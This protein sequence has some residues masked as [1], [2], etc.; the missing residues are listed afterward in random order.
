MLIVLNGYPGVGKLTIGQIVAERLSG[1]LLDNHTVYNPA[2]ALTAFKSPAF[3]AA[4]R[5]MQALTD[6]LIDRLDADTPLVL[7]ETLAGSGPWG[8]ECWSRIEKLGQIRGPFYV[9]HLLCDLEENMRRIE[10]PGRASKRKPRDAEMALRNHKDGYRLYGDD[11]KNLL[12]LDV[13]DLSPDRAAMEVCDWI[14]LQ[15]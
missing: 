7:T 8:D 9:V 15:S 2:F 12:R 4:A 6:D 3:Y 10:E 13:S 14:V 11:T 1:R 5:A